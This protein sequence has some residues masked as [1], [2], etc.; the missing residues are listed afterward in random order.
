[1][2]TI[3]PNIILKSQLITYRLL[4]NQL[5]NRLGIEHIE[6]WF[7]WS[8]LN[9][10]CKCFEVMGSRDFILNHCGLVTPYGHTVL[11]LH[12]PGYWLA[13]WWHQSNGFAGW[14]RQ[15]V[16]WANVELSSVGFRGILLTKCYMNFS[17]IQLIKWVWKLYF[18]NYRSIS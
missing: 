11:G 18:R 4:V 2:Q 5:L 13:A 15:V 1:M 17:R 7:D 10:I 9:I 3:H 16:T 6:L 8:A 12:W 14:W